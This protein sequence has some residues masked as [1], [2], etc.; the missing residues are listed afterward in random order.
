MTV[1]LKQLTHLDLNLLVTLHVL[2]EQQSVS[3]AAEKL[4]LTQPALSKALGR[5]REVF[6]DPLFSRA[7]RGLVPTPFALALRE[8]LQRV[9]ESASGLLAAEAFDPLSW[10]GEFSLAVN[11]MMQ[12][13]LLPKLIDLLSRKAPGVV[14]KV[15]SQYENQLQGLESGELDFVLN[16]EFSGLSAAFRSE[17]VCNDTP[18]IYARVGHPLHKKEFRREDMQRYPRISVR[19]PDMEK[20]MLF[21]SHNLQPSADSAW[22]VA[23]ETDNMNVA[24]G[25]LARTDYLLPGSGLL[26][27]LA[28]RELNFK[29]LQAPGAAAAFKVANCLVSHQRVQNSAPHQWLRETMRQLLR[30]LV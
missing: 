9:L 26:A 8:P 12:L 30:D 28:T 7:S 6:D 10:K 25:I 27:G 14:L 1:N 17:V 19:M 3:L 22:P 29:P 15:R 20:F 11:G 24:L 13:I 4:H 23:C 21:Q 2:L 5:L 18:A 16:L